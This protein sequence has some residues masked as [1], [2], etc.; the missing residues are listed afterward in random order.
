MPLCVALLET[1]L[2]APQPLILLVDDVRINLDLLEAVLQAE[3]RIVRAVNGL[4]AIE[5]AKELNPDL[6][7]LDV[8]MPEI[9][10]FETCRRLKADPQTQAIP[11]IFVSALSEI[12]DEAQG[13]Q[14]GAIDYIMKPIRPIIVKARIRNHIALK[15]ARD[16][17]EEMTIRD[18]L[19]G[20]SNRRRFDDMLAQEWLRARRR[21]A[22]LA[23]LLADIDHFKLYNDH[24][25]HTSGDVALREVAQA[26]DKAIRRPGDLAARYGGEEFACI[27]PD[28]D[29]VGAAQLAERLCQAVCDLGIVHAH[30]SAAQCVTL[31]IGGV[32]LV[33]SVEDEPR[34]L[35][36]LADV[37]LYEAK[38]AG[39]N[40]A[41]IRQD[42]TS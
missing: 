34:I 3:Y 21:S 19:T 27:L 4:E 31:S 1:A 39:R 18:A 2:T 38:R 24:Y 35:V 17:L 25:G 28:T 29:S 32:S 13:L 7:L 41:S 10:G 8:M 42:G 16:Q 9:D 33:P 22:P 30:S 12:G 20:I 23:L 37:Q 11:V 14:V 5:R 6:I 36:D 15:Q 26:L 40:R